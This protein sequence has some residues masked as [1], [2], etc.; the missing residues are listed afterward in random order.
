MKSSRPNVGRRDSR[1]LRADEE[2]RDK[3][4]NNK[5]RATAFL[6][7]RLLGSR[8]DNHRTKAGQT[9]VCFVTSVFRSLSRSPQL[10]S[11][12]PYVMENS[13]KISTTSAVGSG[14]KLPR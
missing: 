3:P 12:T 5:S 4:N 13:D 9:S 14:G 1:W 11:Q 6:K 10:P 8:T 7:F 2:I